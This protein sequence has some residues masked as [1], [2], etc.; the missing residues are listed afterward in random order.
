MQKSDLFKQL[1]Q[2]PIAAA[3][4]S[5]LIAQNSHDL[6]S[7]LTE[8]YSKSVENLLGRWD[9]AK[10]GCT[11][12]EYRDAEMISLDLANYIVGNGLICIGLGEARQRIVDWH[13]ERNTNTDLNS[14]LQ[15]VLEKSGLFSVDEDNGLLSFRYRSF[16]EY[17][18]AL[19]CY[20]K[21]KLLD[22]STAFDPYWISIHFFQTG[23]LGDCEEHL[24]QLLKCKVG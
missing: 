5:R 19:S 1:P 20:K 13:K 18:Y 22:V 17:L 2:S 14:L 7:N 12:K 15:R 24:F 16:G 11:E 9:M 8:L 23:L 10:G 3:L 6:P 4:L 21:H